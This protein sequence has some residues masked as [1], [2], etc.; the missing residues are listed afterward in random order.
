MCP[1]VRTSC[2]TTASVERSCSRSRC[3]ITSSAPPAGGPSLDSRRMPGPPDIEPAGPSADCCRAEE[4]ESILLV[5]LRISSSAVATWV[6]PR[7]ITRAQHQ[8][9]RLSRR[10]S[11]SSLREAAGLVPGR[12]GR[13]CILCGRCGG[14]YSICCPLGPVIGWPIPARRGSSRLVRSA[15]WSNAARRDAA[16]SASPTEAY[17]RL[18]TNG[19]C[20]ADAKLAGGAT[21]HRR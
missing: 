7:R 17:S 2:S 14:W 1:T 9:S 5:R 4:L 11:L 20:R 16:P 10:T 19:L 21:Q 6:H 3:T 12:R 8:P 13:F 15:P 18:W